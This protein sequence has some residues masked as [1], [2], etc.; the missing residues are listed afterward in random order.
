VDF[1]S[2]DAAFKFA[3]YNEEPEMEPITSSVAFAALEPTVF[4]PAPMTAEPEKENAAPGAVVLN[5]IF[6]EPVI[7]LKAIPLLPV[8]IEPPFGALR[9]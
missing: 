8:E 5:P 9:S 1:T 3:M 6:P 4:P 7:M 2:H